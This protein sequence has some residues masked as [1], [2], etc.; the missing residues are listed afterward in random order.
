MRVYTRVRVC[1]R[2]GVC[3]LGLD[4]SME[5][6][7]FSPDDLAGTSTSIWRESRSPWFKRDLKRGVWEG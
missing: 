1:V 5:I 3:H 6:A 4:R 7:P 2:E